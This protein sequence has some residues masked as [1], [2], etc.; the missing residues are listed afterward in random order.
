MTREE[1][2][3]AIETDIKIADAMASLKQLG[4]ECRTGIN[5]DITFDRNAIRAI[6]T[7]HDLLLDCGFAQSNIVYIAH[8]LSALVTH[9]VGSTLPPDLAADFGT[10]ILSAANLGMQCAEEVLADDAEK[11][12]SAAQGEIASTNLFGTKPAADA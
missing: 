4:E 9:R 7:I 11:R 6:G 10:Y 5:S 3:K 8:A 1:E 2:D 12:G